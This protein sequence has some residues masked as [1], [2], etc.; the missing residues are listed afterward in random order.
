LGGSLVDAEL[1]KEQMLGI[2]PSFELFVKEAAHAG[3]TKETRKVSSFIFDFH[4]ALAHIN[5]G[6]NSSSHWVLTTGNRTVAGLVV[7]FNEICKDIVNSLN[8]KF[9]TSIERDLPTKRM[10]SRNSQGAMITTETTMIAE[11]S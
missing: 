5:A 7:P 8:G 1:K 2:S 4:K 11:F 9:I 6:T 10:P 3:K